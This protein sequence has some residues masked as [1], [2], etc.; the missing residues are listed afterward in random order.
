VTSEVGICNGALT[1]VG[2]ETI[3]SLGEDSKAARLCNLMFDR[4]RDSI[5]RAHPWN[6]A[7]KRVELAELTTTPI[8]GFASQF[9]LPTD[10]LR[11]LRT[12]EDQIP[13]QIE[14]RI[15]LTDAGTV[16]IKYIAQITD[17]NLFDSLFIQALEDRIAS[18]LAYSLSDNRALSVDMRAKY[19]E[20]LKE[21]RA[22]DGQEGVSDI[23]E[24][25]EWL[26][27]R[28]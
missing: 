13:H 11:V 15:L 6:F 16:Q 1:K 17:P 12:D 20:T 22:M 9:Q 23:V 27:I 10:C 5:L 8:F 3:I 7:I 25:D 14:G 19:K 28:L 18:E 4:L 24:A 26:N 21:A 2:E